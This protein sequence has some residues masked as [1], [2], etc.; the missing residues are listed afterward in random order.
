MF[1]RPGVASQAEGQP[2]VAWL[3][4]EPVT[5]T[6]EEHGRHPAEAIPD[7]EAIPTPRQTPRQ[8][9]EIDAADS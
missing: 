8:H 7:E 3:G 9:A 5:T 1:I 2:V 6:Q 4:T